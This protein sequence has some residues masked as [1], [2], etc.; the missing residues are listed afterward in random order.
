MQRSLYLLLNKV[1]LDLQLLIVIFVGS[2]NNL[3]L[4]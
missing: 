2:S 1:I 4:R 3:S